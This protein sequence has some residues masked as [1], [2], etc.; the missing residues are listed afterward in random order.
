MKSIENTLDATQV[1]FQMRLKNLVP[2]SSKTLT[3]NSTNL[4]LKTFKV[5]QFAS[6]CSANNVD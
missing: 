5:N 1:R 6:W 3:Q 4:A 2:H